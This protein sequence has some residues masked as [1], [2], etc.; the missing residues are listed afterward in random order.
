MEA[1][2]ESH[3]QLQFYKTAGALYLV[4]HLVLVIQYLP[5]VLL[6]RTNQWHR[7]PLENLV[8]P[9]DLGNQLVPELREFR[10]TRC[11]RRHQSVPYLLPV[12]AILASRQDLRFPSVL[13]LPVA[14]VVHSV[15]SV[16]AAPQVR[17]HQRDPVFRAC[18]TVPGHRDYPSG[19]QDL[20]VRLD[21]VVPVGQFDHCFL[22]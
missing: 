3:S 21:L 13:L 4:D 1:K 17:C 10:M 7:L 18:Q 20:L 5:S 22:N 14:L 12:P 11:L 9:V 16:P 2:L 8:L 6:D 19:Q 15:H